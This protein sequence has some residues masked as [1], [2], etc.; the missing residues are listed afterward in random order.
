VRT[1]TGSVWAELLIALVVEG[2]REFMEWWQ[3]KLW[4]RAA[5]AV[6]Q[7]PQERATAAEQHVAWS[8]RD[9]SSE[10]E[11]L[12]AATLNRHARRHVGLAV[13]VWWQGESWTFVRGRIFADRSE[14]PTAGTI[15]EVGSIT[16]VFT[17]TVLADMVEEGLAA[18]DDPVQR[19]LP[20]GVELPVH[21]RP[22][23]LAD[24]ATQTSG[25]PRLPK[26]LIWRSLRQRD[27]PYAGFT[28][29]ELERAVT[30]ASPRRAPGEKLRYSN[31]G[32][33]L[34]GH[35]LALRTGQSYEQ[36]VRSR[37]CDP[38]GLADTRISIPT[39]ATPRFADGHNRRGRPVPHWD[40]Q[41]LAGAGALRATVADLLRF[42]EL[43]LRPPATRLGRAA[44]ATHEARTRRG[45]LSQGLGWVGLPLR[46]GSC[47]VLWH[48]GGTGGFRSF[49]GFVKE[50]ET[51]VVVLSNCARS[52]DAIGFRILEASNPGF[53]ERR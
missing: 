33:G 40:L 30:R 51:G 29:A 46:G 18:P 37:I 49:L 43:Q 45:R 53:A 19:Y 32:Y 3:S 41:A 21:G 38:L 1:H 34:L 12:V 52:V 26:G 10:V 25:L 13:G 2:Y 35:A 28:D 22:I 5:T 4:R 8:T 17:A 31:L 20:D 15:F 44:L 48:N 23:T 7:E 11:R 47:Q 16:K 50:G 39:E 9:R 27:N 24:L 36:L 42:L 6:G 14:R